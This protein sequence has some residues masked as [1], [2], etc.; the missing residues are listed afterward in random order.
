MSDKGSVFRIRFMDAVQAARESEHHVAPLLPLD[1]ETTKLAA[2][3]NGHP[4]GAEAVWI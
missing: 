3:T 4:N 2:R 1:G